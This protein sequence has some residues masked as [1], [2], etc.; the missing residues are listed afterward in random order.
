MEQKY[1]SFVSPPLPGS[2]DRLKKFDTFVPVTGLYVWNLSDFSQSLVC[3]M[4]F[5]NEPKKF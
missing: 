1:D 5:S 4:A 2:Y 3:L